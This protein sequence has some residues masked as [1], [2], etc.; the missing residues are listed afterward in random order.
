MASSKPPRKDG[1]VAKAAPATT[2]GTVAILYAKKKDITKSRDCKDG[3]HPGNRE[4]QSRYPRGD[5]K[6]YKG[7]AQHDAATVWR[8]SNHA[9]ERTRRRNTQRRGAGTSEQGQRG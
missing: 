5:Q 4:H 9:D 2:I 7:S 8:A 3:Q 1:A 6:H